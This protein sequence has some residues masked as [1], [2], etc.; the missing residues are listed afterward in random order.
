DAPSSARE[1]ALLADVAHSLDPLTL[2]K[3]F[4]TLGLFFII[5]A[6]SGLLVGFFFPGDS[7]LFTA[8]ILAASGTLS[9]PVIA[10]G[11]TVAAVAGVS[12][13]YAFGKSVGRRLFERDDS[14]LFHRRHLRRAEAFYERH[15]GKALILARFVPVV[16]TFAPIVAGVSL[17][18]YRRFVIFNV[19]GALLWATGLT[20][21][22]YFV[23][24]LIP[25]VD[26]YL[27]PI[28]GLII[29]VSVLPAAWHAYREYRGD[30]T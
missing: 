4:G 24:N 14:L 10:I 6:E 21:A 11:C 26:R 22:G 12:V 2:L 5:F 8:G 18:D 7:L 23:G 29:V 19:V 3:T 20:V 25:N 27:L 9:L 30:L 16:R 13:G 1:A 28:V 15:G 17:M